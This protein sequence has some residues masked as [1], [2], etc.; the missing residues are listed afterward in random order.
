MRQV[1]VLVRKVRNKAAGTI[2]AARYPSNKI[3]ECFCSQG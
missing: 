3:H 1:Q 2:G